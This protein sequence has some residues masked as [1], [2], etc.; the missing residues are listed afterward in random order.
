[1]FLLTLAGLTSAALLEHIDI[2]PTLCDL[3]GILP[4]ARPAA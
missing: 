1:M 2:M 3:A 4:Q